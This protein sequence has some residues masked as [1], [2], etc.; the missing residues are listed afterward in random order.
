MSSEVRKKRFYKIAQPHSYVRFKG[1]GD[2]PNKQK[3]SD[4]ARAEIR[5]FFVCVYTHTLLASILLCS[6]IHVKM[7]FYLIVCLQYDFTARSKDTGIHK[8][9]NNIVTCGTQKLCDPK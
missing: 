3:A 5:R 4:S 2:C 8:T 1:I 7:S 9:V 6:R